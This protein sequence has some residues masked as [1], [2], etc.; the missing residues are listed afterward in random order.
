MTK[1]KSGHNNQPRLPLGSQGILNLLID[2]KSG[3]VINLRGHHRKPPQTAI[4]RLPLRTHEPTEL[5]AENTNLARNPSLLSQ[6]ASSKKSNLNFLASHETVNIKNSYQTDRDSPDGKHPFLKPQ[7][8][9]KI[10]VSQAP[11][12]TKNLGAPKDLDLNE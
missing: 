1:A 12:S 8:V 11:S 4:A 3:S 6:K 2:N 9:N 5:S 7:S 10:R